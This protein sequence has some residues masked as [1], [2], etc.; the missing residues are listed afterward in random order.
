MIF[1][2]VRPLFRLAWPV[3]VAQ[4]A[5]VLNAVIDTM[6]AGRLSAVDL[7]AVGVAASI[8]VTVFVTC[9]GVLLALTPNV[10]HLY[11][12][13]QLRRI[14]EEIHRAAW[15][16]AGLAVFGVIL[17]QF[18]E[19]LLI[20]TRLAPEVE[21]KVRDYLAVMA[22]TMPPALA[23]RVFYGLMAGIGRPRAVMIFNLFGLAAKVPLNG[24]FMYG[25]GMGAAGCAAATA[26][27]AW[28]T[29]GA[30][31]W[32]CAR[33]PLFSQYGLFDAWGRPR[34]RTLLPLLRLGLPIGATFLVDVTAFTF[35]ALFIT[36]LGT[37]TSAAHQIAANL[38]VL[39]FMLP[40][41][42]G[43]A[44]M[45][46][47]GQ[48]L[49]AGDP[50]RARHAGLTGIVLGMGVSCL[51]GFAI[52][53]GATRLAAIYSVDPAVRQLTIPLIGAVAFYHVAD[54]LQAVTINV[55][56]G[57]KKTTIPMLVY[58]FSLWGVGLGGGIV[59][60]LTDL[61]GPARGAQG[62]WLSATGSLVMAGALMF[63]YFLRVARKTPAPGVD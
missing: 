11:G 49:G 61:A 14:G 35:M 63:F 42:L 15:L 38:A 28:G 47:A 52:W 18:P 25:L 57:Y 19:P 44:A 10:A 22:W 5:I 16:A 60:G 32:W 26:V 9:M 43:N 12:A 31:W 13:G 4:V 48:A 62:F 23:F 37:A 6:M 17:L 1:A 56:R 55:L 34:L 7:A 46:L 54:A 24:L 45:V 40:M 2:L 3:F 30:A 36:R 59:L 8:Y 21:I 29:A 39:G 58:A 51:V 50:A 41:S 53:I 20:L 27:I 33:Q